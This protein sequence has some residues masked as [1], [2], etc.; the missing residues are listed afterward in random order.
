MKKTVMKELSICVG[1]VTM[2]FFSKELFLARP[3]VRNNGIEIVVR[4][5]E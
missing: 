5:P 4:V 1:D 2:F 3:D